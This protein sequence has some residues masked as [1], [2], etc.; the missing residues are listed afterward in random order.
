M[1][2]GSPKDTFVFLWRLCS[3]CVLWIKC[4]RPIEDILNWITKE[5][6]EAFLLQ[7][8]ATYE[9]KFSRIFSDEIC[10]EAGMKHFNDYLIFQHPISD[11][12]QDNFFKR[13]RS[14]HSDTSDCI[15]DFSHSIFQIQK[16]APEWIVI[17][18]MR[19]GTKIKVNSWNNQIFHK[20]LRKNIFQGY[21][22]RLG[23][24]YYLSEGLVF[25]PISVN[26][27]IRKF[28]RKNKK[29]DIAQYFQLLS[30]LFKGFLSYQ[31]RQETDA[32]KLYEH[33]IKTHSL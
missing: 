6:G 3:Q 5:F 30:I 33:V 25:H 28:L 7:A 29:I 16:V 18:D 14:V 10:Y 15:S 2:L 1:G 4:M 27:M 9:Q 8:K 17:V 31:R 22:Y 24:Y 13:Y 21:V 19:Q 11:D 20:N 26:P 23:E 12:S 32:D